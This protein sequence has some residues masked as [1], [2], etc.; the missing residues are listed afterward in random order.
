MKTILDN[1]WLRPIA[2]T[3]LVLSILMT[4]GCSGCRDDKDDVA[5][6][7]EDK[8]KNKKRKDD[9]ETNTPIL[10]PGLYPK[11]AKEKA[12]DE[13]EAKDNPLAR[14]MQ[15]VRSSAASNRVK[16]GHWYTANFPAIANNFNADGE[17]TAYAVD[18]VNK[19]VRVPATDYF[20]N[21]TR[22]VSLP[23]GEWKNFE[24]TVFIPPRNKKVTTASVN[25]SLNRSAS[26]LAQIMLSQ[27]T[28]TMKS[29]QFHMMLMSTRPDTYKY[30]ELADCI[31]L[32][33][34]MGNG[35]IIPPFY[36][37]VPTMPEK[38]IPL[39]QHALNWTTIAYM[40]W[41]DY[42]PTKLG[43][44][45]EQAILDWLHFGGQLVIS[46]P[47]CLD[48]LQ[49]SFLADYLPAHFDGSRNLTNDDMEE[50]NEN[51]TVPASRNKAQKRIFQ[52]SDKVPLLGVTFKPHDDANFVEGTGEIA[53]ER[54]VGRGRIVI[55]SFSLNAPAVRKWRSFKSFLNGALLRKPARRF[56][57]SDS[58]EIVFEWAEDNT[59]LFDPMVHSTVRFVARDLARNGT[60]KTRT[61][62][63]M[64]EGEVVPQRFGRNTYP[65]D[66]VVPESDIRINQSRSK[67]FSRNLKDA[68][69]YGGYQDASQSGVGGWNDDS[70]I[71]FAA[72]ETL[73]EAAGITP[74]SS[75]FVL[76][77]LGAY[78]LIL[79]PLNWFI[80]RMIGK[81][82]YAWIA[83][84]IIAIVGALMVVKMAA[85]DI[86]F[87]RS[88]TQIGLLEIHSDYSRAHLA[89]YSAL[90]TSLSTRYNAELDNLSAQ[91][92]P[93]GTIDGSA[94]Y[95]S[96]ESLSE[97]KLRRTVDNTLEGFQIQS[98][99]TGL[100]HTEYMLDL[101]GV[102][103]F[104]EN[105]SDGKS[106]LVNSTNIGIN[107]SA[108]I[109]RNED[110]T[111]KFA[112]VGKLAADSDK[113][114]KFETK[115]FEQLDEAWNAN[116]MFQNTNRSSLKI[117]KK[118]LGEVKSATID[119]I[120]S[121]PELQSNLPKFQRLLLQT[122]PET[123]NG[124]TRQQ[125][126]EIYQ[127]VNSAS[128]VSLGRLLDNVLQHL[129]I[130]PGEYRLIG[131]TTQRLG[132]TKFD[133]VSTQI[134]QKTL[135]ITHLKQ[136]E[137]PLAKRDVNGYEDFA[138]ARS[139]LDWERDE[140]EFEKG[141]N[142]ME[143]DQ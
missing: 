139:N 119:Q 10:L 133:P 118:N 77:M 18:G 122:S 107:D 39:P 86:G 36:Y 45:Q 73:K 123:V 81:V 13:K 70:G 26:G 24:T 61:I 6:K 74:P 29:H 103:S 43:A 21:T 96:N 89:E 30:L 105:S 66:S 93:F 16:P 131:A 129:V 68:W 130:S 121:F 72:R 140:E 120:T 33:G 44:E 109:G 7:E 100:L 15:E 34:T 101:T 53:I 64:E 51:W 98:N 1:P 54:R 4:T 104:V 55:S 67:P 126:D 80:F 50:L 115:R 32:R 125:F 75:D 84:P 71:S 128:D 108:V 97:V 28:S 42:D 12:K 132:A 11:S 90:Y 112:W 135:V 35:E 78:L 65:G 49:N 57:K 40:I 138:S 41:D 88:N 62:S 47:D 141:M 142:A 8:K 91:S 56:G 48:R 110:G 59:S 143:D 5:K 87:V 23:K 127:V 83:A 137:L 19:P 134:D 116:P 3:F 114:L 25:Y 82:E 102:I 22:P 17:L 76:K 94:N 46:G 95:A 111:Y 27:P 136:P 37:V 20:L 92:L 60:G 113:E 79:V 63:S 106:L 117:W 85:L 58:D 31:R 52:V 9:F 2:V 14:A 99:S 38:P 69:H 124:Y